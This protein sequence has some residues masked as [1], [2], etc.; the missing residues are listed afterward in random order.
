GHPG[1]VLLEGDKLGTEPHS[2]RLQRVQE[3]TEEIG[4]VDA[5]TRGAQS[6]VYFRERDAYQQVAAPGTRLA[7]RQATTGRHDRVDQPEFAEHSGRVRHQGD[8][9][10][11]GTRLGGALED[12]HVEPA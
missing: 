2:A 7:M 1:A 4:A 10:P 12:S 3:Y 9:S 8:P 5:D 6:S 11:D